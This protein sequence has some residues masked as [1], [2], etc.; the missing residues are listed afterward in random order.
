ME[1]QRELKIS[2]RIDWIKFLESISKINESTI[3]TLSE[4]KTGLLTSL[5]SSA[6]NTL[7]LYGEISGVDANYNGTLNIPDLKKLIR[8][9]DS[10]DTQDLSLTINNNNVEYRGKSLKFKYHLYEDGFLSKPAINVEKIKSFN[11]D[12]NFILKKEQISSIIKGST[13]A[14][15]TNKLYLYTQDGR[16]KGEL[17]DRA[18]HNTDV[19]ALDL[20]EVDFTL[21]PLPINFDNIKLLSFIGEDIKFGINTEYGVTII[22]IS[23]NSIKLKYI[24]TSLTQ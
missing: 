11:Y 19:F 5:V 14:T 16:L 18:R 15:E 7:I 4:G 12:I 24:I 2:N 1:V 22:D 6:D 17:T 13:F 21:S 8:V 20:G 9:V 10:L 23:N 3:L